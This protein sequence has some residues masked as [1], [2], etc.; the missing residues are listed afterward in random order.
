M[1][2]CINTRIAIVLNIVSQFRLFKQLEQNN[3]R[4][5]HEKF[6]YSWLKHK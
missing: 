5:N 2:Y 4:P 3:I 6:S 1:L